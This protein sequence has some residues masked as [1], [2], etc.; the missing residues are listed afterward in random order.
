M[1]NDWKILLEAFP[2]IK[3]NVTLYEG[4]SCQEDALPSVSL[5][6]GDG[7]IR[8]HEDHFKDIERP[9]DNIRDIILAF[10]SFRDYSYE[11]GLPQEWVE[12]FAKKSN[13]ILS[14]IL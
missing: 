1:V 5:S 14:S 3:V 10:S 4:E 7:V 9:K 11:R 13:D 2:F 12:E 6:I 8:V